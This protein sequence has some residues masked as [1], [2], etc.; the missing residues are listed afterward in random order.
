[1]FTGEDAPVE[2]MLN[3]HFF[4]RTYK[5]GQSLIYNVDGFP[6]EAWVINREYLLEMA[7]KAFLSSEGSTL[8]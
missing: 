6:G 3:V 7:Y 2:F 8:Q 4:V 5:P 1:I